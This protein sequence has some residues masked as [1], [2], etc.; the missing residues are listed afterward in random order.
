[1]RVNRFIFGVDV[2]VVEKREAQAMERPES[3]LGQATVSQYKRKLAVNYDSFVDAS[4]VIAQSF[5][6]NSVAPN[7]VHNHR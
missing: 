7:S 6:H 4:C 3:M 5:A 1:M 2:A